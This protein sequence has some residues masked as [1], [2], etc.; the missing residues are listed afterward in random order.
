[1]SA[2]LRKTLCEQCGKACDSRCSWSS[3]LE[4]VP[5]WVA[6]YAP[7][8]VSYSSG[9]KTKDVDSYIVYSCPEYENDHGQ[10]GTAD[11]DPQGLIALLEAVLELARED[12]I[13]F[14]GQRKGIEK[15]IRDDNNWFPDP[16]GAIKSL[17]TA[18]TQADKEWAERRKKRMEEML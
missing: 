10:V 1:M 11:V 7:V 2:Y 14:P 13:D 4:P 18:A 15:W 6:D 8:K 9:S 12:Y 17:R 16:D 3:E 5:G